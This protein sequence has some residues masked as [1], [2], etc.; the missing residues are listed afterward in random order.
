M[1]TDNAKYF[2]NWKSCQQDTQNLAR[3]SSAKSAFRK[4]VY[5]ARAVHEKEKIM[6]KEE[7]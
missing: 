4:F 6:Q 5:P 3:F 7:V 1:A 2:K